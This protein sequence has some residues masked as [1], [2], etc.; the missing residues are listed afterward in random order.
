MNTRNHCCTCFKIVGNFNPDDISEQLGLA[1][2]R[3]W[4][5]GDLRRNGTPYDF[6]LWEIGK[7]TE[8]DVEVENQMRKTVA[9]LQD[10]IPVLNQIRQACDVSFFLEIVPTIYANDINPCLAPSLDII[11]FC[12]ATRTQIDID[13]YVCNS[14]EE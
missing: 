3:A 5:I 2:E 9:V 1:P 6:A 8:Y 11:D 12:H 14:E 7:C 4:K 13:I 10:K